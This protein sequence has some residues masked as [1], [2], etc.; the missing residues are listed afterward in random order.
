MANSA[1]DTK[2]FCKKAYFECFQDTV[3]KLSG[4]IITEDSV[5]VN[6]N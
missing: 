3:M 6:E 4:W 1:N 2:I 5:L